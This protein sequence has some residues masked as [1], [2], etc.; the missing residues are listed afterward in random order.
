MAFQH[1]IQIENTLFMRFAFSDFNL[2]EESFI[3]FSTPN[4][5]LI[6]DMNHAMIENFGNTT[7]IFNGN[8]VTITLYHHPGDKSIFF[9][10]DS[11]LV[12]NNEWEFECDGGSFCGANSRISDISPFNKAIGR[13]YGNGTAW[14][15][16]NHKVVTAYH[17]ITQGIPTGWSKIIEF[18]VPQS[19]PN[20]EPRFSHPDD[21]YIVGGILASGGSTIGENDWAI[22]NVLPKYLNSYTIAYYAWERQGVSLNVKQNFIDDTN[23]WVSGYGCSFTKVSNKTLLADNGPAWYYSI[24]N[25]NYIRFTVDVSPGTSGGPIIDLSDG[26]VIG[27]VT[28][29]GCSVSGFNT[30]VSLKAPQFWN[31]LEGG[32]RLTKVQRLDAAGNP[33]PLTTTFGWWKA[34]QFE[35][36][37]NNAMIKL[38][39]DSIEALKANSNLISNQKYYKWDFIS[40]YLNHSEFYF[41]NQLPRTLF[42]YFRNSVQNI[43]LQ[44]IGLEFNGNIPIELGFSDPW[45]EDFNDSKG[46]RNRGENSIFHSYVSPFALNDHGSYKGVFLDQGLFWIAPLYHVYAP[47]TINVM[48]PQLQ[49]CIV[50]I[51]TIGRQVQ[52]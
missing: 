47:G 51:S 43:T 22:I 39:I 1:T 36:Q 40:N 33:F 28:S 35:A 37:P 6:Y 3:R 25:K 12:S 21:Q 9:L 10:I 26:S 46:V 42:A 13:L 29:P 7:P 24:N 27:I 11:L 48:F 15:S 38:K 49:E 18:N 8:E 17:V 52:F 16:S 32:V 5:T 50:F 2:G 41:S 23:A 31:A 44:T 4:D 30:G 19:Q 45:Y 14:I 20:G 34:N